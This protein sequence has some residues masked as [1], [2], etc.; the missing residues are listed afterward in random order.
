MAEAWS[1]SDHLESTKRE[2][3]SRSRGPRRVYAKRASPA[4]RVKRAAA[5]PTTVRPAPLDEPEELDEEAD[6]AAALAVGVP[7]TVPVPDPRPLLALAELPELPD[8]DPPEVELV[9]VSV[10]A[11]VMSSPRQVMMGSSVRPL[12]VTA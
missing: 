6:P 12:F 2:I 1:V 11:L 8:L 10:Y 9:V 3:R 5:D 7:A 4:R